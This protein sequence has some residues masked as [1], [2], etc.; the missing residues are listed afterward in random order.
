[1]ESLKFSGGARA[2]VAVN[3]KLVGLK[4]LIPY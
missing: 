1:M 2:V 3:R 4:N